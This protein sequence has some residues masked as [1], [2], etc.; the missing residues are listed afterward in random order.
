MEQVAVKAAGWLMVP[1]VIAVQ[2]LASVTVYE[3]EPAAC[4]NVPVPLYGAVPPLALTVT[5]EFA[6]LQRIAVVDDDAVN[7]AALVTVKEQVEKLPQ[8][9]VA[10]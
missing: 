9:S 5:V 8:P 7:A 3:Y 1:V 10:L 2:P 4:K 6:P